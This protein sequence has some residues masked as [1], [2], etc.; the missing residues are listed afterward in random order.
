LKEH[1]GWEPFRVRNFLVSQDKVVSWLCALAKSKGKVPLHFLLAG[2]TIVTN[3][4]LFEAFAQTNGL[5]PQDVQERVRFI[6]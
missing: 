5:S 6:Q 2:L 4:L 3:H 1:L